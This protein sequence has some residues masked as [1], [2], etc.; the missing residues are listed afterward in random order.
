M[1][2]A[3]ALAYE[4]AECDIM[5]RP[6]RNPYADKLVNSTLISHAYGQKGMIEA[7]SGFFAYCIIMGEHGFLPNKLFGIRKYFDSLSLNDIEDSYGQEWTHNERK[8][9]E[10]TCN[11]AFFIA[12]VVMQWINVILCKTRHLSIFQQGMGNWTIN[13][14][15]IFETVLAA[16]LCYTPGLNHALNMAPLR[17]EWW[18]A[19][20][21]FAVLLF[22][23]EELRKFIIQNLPA[24]SWLEIETCY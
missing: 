5:R 4:K 14:G 19:A 9:L 2:P 13:F 17:V 24:K 15:I 8:I 18:F 20:I 3:I 1:I 12:I 6:P 23:Y 21:P 7:I 22:V 11:T 10:T 16:F